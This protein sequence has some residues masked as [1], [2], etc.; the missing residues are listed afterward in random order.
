M[1]D[2]SYSITAKERMEFEQKFH[3]EFSRHWAPIRGYC[4][5]R[6]VFA[7][8]IAVLFFVAIPEAEKALAALIAGFFI[9]WGFEAA[10]S[11]ITSKY[12]LQFLESL[13]DVEKCRTYLRDDFLFTENR[14]HL[15]GFPLSSVSKVF[16]DSRFMYIDFSNMGRT[17]IPLSAF[18]DENTRL[19]FEKLFL[20]KKT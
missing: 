1:T 11:K 7:I 9:F 19:E 12:Y 13:A 5:I 14:G 6:T 2:F 10:N 17:R 3:A 8:A 4:L 20:Q 15:I 16:V 18:P